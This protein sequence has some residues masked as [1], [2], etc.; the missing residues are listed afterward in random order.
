MH[1]CAVCHPHLLPAELT[2]WAVV[3]KSNPICCLLPGNNRVDLDKL[4]SLGYAN[5][6]CLVALPNVMCVG[7]T[8]DQD[9]LAD[10]SNFGL[11]AVDMSAPG[12]IRSTWIGEGAWGQGGLGVCCRGGARR[13]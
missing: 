1:C 8:D 11:Q 3:R 6:P 13:V 4:V 12:T 2:C 10:Y 9:R 7:A 5:N